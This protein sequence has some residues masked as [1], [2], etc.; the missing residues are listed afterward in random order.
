MNHQKILFA[1]CQNIDFKILIIFQFGRK[2]I[3]SH[4]EAEAERYRTLDDGSEEDDEAFTGGMEVQPDSSHDE[5][6]VSEGTC[7]I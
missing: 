7:T 5:L 3:K 4:A 1:K 2:R 6:D